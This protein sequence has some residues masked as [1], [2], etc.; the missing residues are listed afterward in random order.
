[1]DAPFQSERIRAWSEPYQQCIDILVI[2]QDSRGTFT[3]KPIELEEVKDHFQVYH[4]PTLRIGIERAQ[5]LMD[6]LWRCGLRP[7]EGTGS[8]GALA[9]TQ[10]HLEDMRKLVFDCKIAK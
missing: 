3:A 4:E 2:R 5:E 9:A 10:R 6:D 1:M 8:A 7:T